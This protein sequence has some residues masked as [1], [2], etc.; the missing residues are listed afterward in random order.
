M[1]SIQGGKG[2]NEEVKTSKPILNETPNPNN[3]NVGGMNEFTQP[4]LET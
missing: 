3:V 1:K 4:T 2:V